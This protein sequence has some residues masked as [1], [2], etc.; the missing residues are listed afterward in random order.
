MNTNSNYNLIKSHYSYTFQE[1]SKLLQIHIRTI[2]NWRH[3]GLQVIDANSKPYLTLGYELKQFIKQSK[4]SR[5]K[6]LT[7]SQFYCLKCRCGRE[8][9]PDTI[10]ANF[11]NK[12][13][14][15]N[16]HQII[17]KGICSECGSKIRR[18]TTEEKYKKE[19]CQEI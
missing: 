1:I 12:V 2:Q 9:I 13:I 6:K 18:F 4:D 10:E 17:L 7:D 16:Q 5:K 3:K 14:G 19:Q 11:T 15:K 8:A